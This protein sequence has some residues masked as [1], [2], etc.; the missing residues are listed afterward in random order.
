MPY[1]AAIEHGAMALFGEKYGDIVRVV[2]IPERSVELCGGTHVANTGQIGMFRFV[3]E[4]GVAA[5]VRRIEA[6][7]GPAAYAL[8][9]ALERQLNSATN[10]L[11]TTPEHLAR[12]AESLL[13][14]NKNLQK[15]VEELLR[16]S[17]GGDSEF[18]EQRVGDVSLF[19]GQSVLSDR[20]QIG[21]VLDA[22]R[23]EHTN[24]I[25]ALFTTGDRPGIHVTVTDDLVARGIKAGDLVNRIARVSGGRGGGRPHFASAGAGDPSKIEDAKSQV[26]DIV[27]SVL[28]GA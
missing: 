14:D 22:F 17:G 13:Q 20:G 5:G 28:A 3:S 25:A 23:G 4:S 24:A 7:T 19:I 26:P 2:D 1:R 27:G 8:V 10:V 9:R 16:A 11:R 6:V 15:R 18:S 12:R 21:T